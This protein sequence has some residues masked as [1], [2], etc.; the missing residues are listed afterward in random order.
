MRERAKRADR[1]GMH[2]SLAM[3]IKR[4]A[5]GDGSETLVFLNAVGKC[6]SS[7]DTED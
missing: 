5:E 6:S 1:L 2:P 4:L 3:A 7:S